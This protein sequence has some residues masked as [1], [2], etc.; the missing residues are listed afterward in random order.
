LQASTSILVILAGKYTFF[1]LSLSAKA[2][3]SIVVTP[4][5]TL[6]VF[7][8]FMFSNERDVIVV[9]PLGTVN[10][11]FLNLGP[12]ENANSSIR[13]NVLGSFKLVKFEQV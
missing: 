4:F 13:V 6:I 11:L 7:K 9:T 3:F 5:S 2:Y 8:S 10:S 12:L 1:K